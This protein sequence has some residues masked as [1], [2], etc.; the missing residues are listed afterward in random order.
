ME[1]P[2]FVK[3]VEQTDKELGEQSHPQAALQ[4]PVRKAG[5][6]GNHPVNFSPACPC[7]QRKEQYEPPETF[8]AWAAVLKLWAS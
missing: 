2:C 4:V 8:P 5:P 1:I 6:Q 3:M 7:P